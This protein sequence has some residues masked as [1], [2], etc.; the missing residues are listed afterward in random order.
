[1][2]GLSPIAIKIGFWLK[3]QQLDWRLQRSE[4]VPGHV[5]E[6][7][8]EQ[9]HRLEKRTL[10]QPDSGSERQ[11]GHEGARENSAAGGIDAHPRRVANRA[12]LY[13]RWT[14]ILRYDEGVRNIL[15]YPGRTPRAHDSSEQAI[16]RGKSHPDGDAGELAMYFIKR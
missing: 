5:H 15:E 9:P 16:D 11:S 1:M 7:Q 4:H 6:Q 14:G 10:R 3:P 8:R 2:E 13:L 12:T